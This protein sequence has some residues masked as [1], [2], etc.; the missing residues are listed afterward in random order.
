MITRQYTPPTCTLEVSAS[1]PYLPRLLKRPVLENLGFQLRFDDP[2]LTEEDYVT[3][4]GDRDQLHRLHRAVKGYI[5]QFLKVSQ[6]QISRFKALQFESDTSRQNSQVNSKESS[7][8][9]SNQQFDPQSLTPVSDIYLQPSGLLYHDLFLGTLANE[10]SGSHVHLGTLQL[11]DLITALEEYQQDLAQMPIREPQESRWLVSGLRTAL[12]ILI[13]IG[14]LTSL[15]KLINYHSQDQTL[16]ADPEQDTEQL[17]PPNL[18]TNRPETPNF[19]PPPPQPVPTPTPQT[20][21]N[22]PTVDAAPLPVPVPL[23]PDA[24]TPPPAET[25]PNVSVQEDGALVI[26]TEPVPVAVA[27]EPDTGVVA[28]PPPEPTAVPN[29][30]PV[31][32]A[33]QPPGINPAGLPPAV[34]QLPTLENAAPPDVVQAPSQDSSII[35]VTDDDRETENPGVE[36]P[37]ETV[38]ESDPL[39]QLNKRPQTLAAQRERDTTLFDEIEQVGEVRT[40]FQS[41]WYPPKQLNRSLQYTLQLN[42]DGSIQSIMPVGQ[43]SVDQLPN[44]DLPSVGDTFVSPTED[45]TTPRIRVL[46]EPNGRVQAF[47][48]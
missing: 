25:I 32:S 24:V 18:V 3:V 42:A 40:Y 26:P 47:L 48:E 7:A 27:P 38:S 35:S 12:T 4:Q 29:S 9:L 20:A 46:L 1:S 30:P 44:L 21:E 33:P 28:T 22:L 45:G 11:F 41:N 10:Q 2:R 39:A 17:S 19:P 31:N 43:A 14:S 6:I 37:E 16:A 15:I 5:Q 23:F 8:L 13:G 36:N 34:I